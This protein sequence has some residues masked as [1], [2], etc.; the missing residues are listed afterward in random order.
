M[1]I[2]R[3][4]ALTAGVLLT[5]LALA[6]DQGP[7]I[8]LGVGSNRIA[9]MT[10]RLESLSPSSPREYFLLGEEIASESPDDV[11]RRLARQLYVLAYEI[12]KRSQVPDPQLGGSV[13]LALAAIAESDD[14]KRWLTALAETLA[15]EGTPDMRRIKSTT[16]SRD[17][18]A[19]DLATMLSFVR[20]GEGR[21]AE[22]LLEKLGVGDLLEKCDK[23]L[24]PG[25]GGAAQVRRRID[26][27]PN[28][29]QCRGHR[30][31]KDA[32]GVHLCPTCKGTPGP[33]LPPGELVGHIRTESSL[34]SGQQRS[35]AGQLIADAGATL[36]ELDP[37]ELPAT[38]GVSAARPLWRSGAWVNDPSAPASPPNDKKDTNAAPAPEATTGH[39]TAPGKR[40]G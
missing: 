13:C 9:G 20:I 31:V 32:A 30:S 33:T 18:A 35:W 27:W 39:P 34:L 21:R 8:R 4:I 36:R 15:P 5:S 7:G 1:S 14:E 24:L 26:E 16:A 23:L 6:Q 25:V 12:D 29:P 3:S 28:C 10:R 11:D 2:L 19:F 40:A 22:K 38:F 37:S 17:P